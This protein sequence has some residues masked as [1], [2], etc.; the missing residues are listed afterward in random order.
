MSD[1]TPIIPMLETRALECVRD[2]RLLFSD[3]SIQL[4]AGEVLQIEGTNG[5][6]KTSL[7][8]ILCGLRLAE[9]G[10]VLWQGE[11]I[12]HAREDYYANM[13][14]IGH[15]PCIKGDLTTLENIRSLLDTRSQ[16]V[17]ID[18]VDVVLEKVGLAGFDDVQSKALSSGQRRRILLAF[19]LLTK[20]K[21]WILDEPLTALDVHGVELV[22]SMLM[23]HQEAGGSA[24]FT[25]HHGMQLPCEMRSASLGGKC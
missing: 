8:R 9:E 23:E 3:L 6:G 5:S 15:L 11:E 18:E 12:Q 25:T 10:Q 2:D 22:E 4:A 17:S 1:P 13:V 24:V 14:Y 16:S 7:L 20:A 19:L 21:L